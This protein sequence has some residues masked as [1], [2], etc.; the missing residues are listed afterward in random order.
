MDEFHPTIAQSSGDS[1][2]PYSMSMK[3][4]VSKDASSGMTVAGDPTPLQVCMKF[5]VKE[6]GKG[7]QSDVFVDIWNRTFMLPLLFV[8]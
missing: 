7:A 1:I 8:R 6:L 5:L 3:G 4:L 2:D